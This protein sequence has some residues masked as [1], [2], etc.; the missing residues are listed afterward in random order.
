[1]RAFQTSKSL[2]VDG[3]VG[4]QTWAALIITVRQG[5]TGDAVPGCRRSSSSGTCPATPA[6]AFKWT[7]TLGQ[8]GQRRPGLPACPVPRHSFSRR[9][10]DRRTGH[11]ASLGQWHAVLLASDLALNIRTRPDNAG[12]LIRGAERK[13]SS[14]RH[15][16]RARARP[17]PRRS[18]K[19]APPPPASSHTVAPAQRQ[20]WRPSST[21]MSSCLHAAKPA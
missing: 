1:M 11:L 18:A 3:I 16:A 14:S 12:T 13:L 21:R 20:P 5:N 7:G 19:S 2:S 15:T 9:G 8:D 6:R 4:P 17:A 10:R